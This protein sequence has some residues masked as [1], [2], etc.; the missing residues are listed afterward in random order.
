MERMKSR[1]FLRR[2]SV[3][4]L[5][6]SPLIPQVLLEQESLLLAQLHQ[7]DAALTGPST[8]DHYTTFHDYQF[9]EKHL[10]AVWT[11]MEQHDQEY[12]DLRRG[13]PISWKELQHILKT[14]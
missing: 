5:H 12:V 11:E 10:N 6:Q 13:R 4:E 1:E 3:S 14:Y 7:L 2:L 8:A 9:T